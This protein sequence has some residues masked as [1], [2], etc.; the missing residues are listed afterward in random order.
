LGRAPREPQGKPARVSE[1]G[2]GVRNEELPADGRSPGFPEPSDA[3]L[4][5]ENAR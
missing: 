5:R 1:G 4:R 3:H 2:V